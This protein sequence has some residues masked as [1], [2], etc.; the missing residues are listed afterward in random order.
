MR[1]EALAAVN[2]M[3]TAAWDVKPYI[4]V[5]IYHGFG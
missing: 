3:N 4:L 1:S 2:T 5:E